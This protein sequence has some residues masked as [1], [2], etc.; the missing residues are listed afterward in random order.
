MAIVTW[1]LSSGEA[2]GRVGG[3]VYNTW[4]GRSYVKTHTDPATQFSDKQIVVRTIAANVTAAWQLLDD[5]QRSAWNAFACAHLLPSWTGSPKRLSGYNWFLKLGWRTASYF[6]GPYFLPPE[7]LGIY[8]IHDFAV[9]AYLLEIAVAW[10][11]SVAIPDE[12]VY[13][14]MWLEGPW[15]SPRAPS[16]K[17]ARLDTAVAQDANGWTIIAPSPGYYTVHLRAVLNSG[18]CTPYVH[19]TVQ[20]T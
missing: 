2:R 18:W 16:I 9:S 8:T 6:G 3:L 15:N 12:E 4:R 20:A 14:E 13:V 19:Q 5:S 11:Q 1:P 10:T 7:Q 17:R